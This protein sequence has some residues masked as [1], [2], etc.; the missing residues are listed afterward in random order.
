MSK[1]RIKGFS[2]LH[3][4][5]LLGLFIYATIFA[6]A[7]T[8]ESTVMQAISGVLVALTVFALW[9]VRKR[10]SSKGDHASGGSQQPD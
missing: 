7:I 5:L 4:R 9:P 1:L 6:G 2:F 8:S 3:A 10:R